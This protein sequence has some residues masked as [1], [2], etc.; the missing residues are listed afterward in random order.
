MHEKKRDEDRRDPDGHEPFIADVAW[1]MKH[2]S[3]GRQ[4]IVKLLDQRLER[5]PLNP[6]AERGNSTLEELLVRE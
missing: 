5:R 4:L 2:Q 3:L 1:W 6:Q